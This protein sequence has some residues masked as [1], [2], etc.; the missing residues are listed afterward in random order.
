MHFEE[1]FCLYAMNLRMQGSWAFFVCM[2]LILHTRWKSTATEN[3]RSAGKVYFVCMCSDEME[4][5]PLEV[6]PFGKVWE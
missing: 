2:I 1:I 5:W 3:A 6:E 4:K